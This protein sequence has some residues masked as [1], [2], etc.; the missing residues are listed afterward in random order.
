MVKNINIKII[1][2]THKDKDSSDEDLPKAK[3]VT[4]SKPVF[5]DPEPFRHVERVY[6]PIRKPNN[7][8][9]TVHRP[10][11]ISRNNFEGAPL[12]ADGILPSN[13]SSF[14]ET[15]EE[16]QQQQK[17]L[18]RTVCKHDFSLLLDAFEILVFVFVPIFGLFFFFLRRR[19]ICRKCGLSER[20]LKRV[21]FDRH[22]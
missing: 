11:N 15:G 7:N 18:A 16:A 22:T 21:R 10:T 9:N 17:V 8:N 13:S 14:P 2:D 1:G 12:A 19:S 20:A 6:S 3:P 4:D 5:R